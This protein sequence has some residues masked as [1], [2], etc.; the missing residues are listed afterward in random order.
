MWFTAVEDK[1]TLKGML[2]TRHKDPNRAERPR[3]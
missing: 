2:A 1:L 3:E